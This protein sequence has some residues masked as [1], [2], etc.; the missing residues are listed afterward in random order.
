[1][2]DNFFVVNLTFLMESYLI[3]VEFQLII[4]YN[5]SISHSKKNRCC[6]IVADFNCF[7]SFWDFASCIGPDFKH[8]NGG[9]GGNGGN[10]GYK[11][12]VG[13]AGGAG[14]LAGGA[15]GDAGAPG[16]IGIQCEPPAGSD[17]CQCD[18]GKAV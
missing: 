8:G 18:A 3:S 12:K 5:F 7:L 1:M 4:G 13:A 2:P 11:G 17:V 14:G 15:G 9:A 10:G 6:S 16:H